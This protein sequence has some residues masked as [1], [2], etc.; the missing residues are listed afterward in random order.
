MLSKP[1]ELKEQEQNV[2]EAAKE[3]IKFIIENYDDFIVDFSGGKDS[4]AVLLLVHEVAQEI[5]Y[6]KKIKVAFYDEEFVYPETVDVVQDVANADWAELY[7][8]C[9]PLDYELALTDGSALNIIIWDKNRKHMR[10]MPKTGITSTKV[11]NVAKGEEIVWDLV[12]KTNP[13]KKICQ[14]LGVRTDESIYRRFKITGNAK[15]GA[16]SY[17]GGSTITNIK[18]ASPIYDWKEKDIFKYLQSKQDVLKINELYYKALLLKKQLR[19]GPSV[20]WR[21][22]LDIKKIKEES[23]E[24]YEALV[25]AFP[26]LDTTA[27]YI[28]SVAQYSSYDQIIKKYGLSVVGIKKYILENVKEEE[29][30]IMAL[31]RLRDYVRAYINDERYL[32]FNQTREYALRFFFIQALKGYYGKPI[33]LRMNKKQDKLK[34]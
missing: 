7:W 16:F 27:K 30:K 24:H 8:F 21:R 1:V 6:T 11:Y 31:T 34:V 29:I 9:V 10:V 13:S 18:K 28:N 33:V 3:R 23:P 5:G 2:Y 22:K 17:I 15:Q 14:I 25:R 26:S 12:F 20:H 32:K 19:V 4:Q